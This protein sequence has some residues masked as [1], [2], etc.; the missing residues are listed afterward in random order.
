[1]PNAKS[2]P[3]LANAMHSTQHLCNLAQRH[4]D[5]YK[6]AREV[7]SENVMQHADFLLGY[8]GQLASR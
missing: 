1:M 3:H 5:M 2:K 7:A 4:T 8:R 6:H